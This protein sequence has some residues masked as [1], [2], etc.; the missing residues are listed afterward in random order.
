[1]SWFFRKSPF[2]PG[3]DAVHH[4]IELLSKEA[5]KGGPPFT[6]L[7]KEILAREASSLDPLPKELHQRTRE[8]VTQIYETE[9]WDEFEREPKSFT[10]SLEWIEPEYP[11]VLMIAE[12]VWREKFWLTPPLQGWKR[13]NDRLQLVGCALFVV[14]LMFATVI[15]CGFLFRWR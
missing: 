7:E 2:G 5:E 4:V 9:P 15:A 10:D 11:N 3:E 13:V 14:L 12:E 1:M 8:L 6:S